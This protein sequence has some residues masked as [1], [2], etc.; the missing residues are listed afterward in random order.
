MTL[1][2][3]AFVDHGGHTRNR[4]QIHMHL[5]SRA[6]E[7]MKHV[8]VFQLASALPDCCSCPGQEAVESSIANGVWVMNFGCGT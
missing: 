6:G 2:T 4:L 7:Q 3:L 5:K 8:H 1:Q